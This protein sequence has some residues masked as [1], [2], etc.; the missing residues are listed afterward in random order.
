M[1]TSRIYGEWNKTGRWEEEKN[2]AWW[3]WHRLAAQNEGRADFEP[4]NGLSQRKNEIIELWALYARMAPMVVVEIGVAQGGTFAAWCDL[5]NEN[6]TIIGIDRDVNDCRPRPGDPIHPDI[7]AGKAEST[8]NGGGMHVY[9]RANQQVI[10]INGWT[11]DSYVY[12]RL[13][14]VLSGRKIDF[15][16]HD[17]SHEANMFEADFKRFWPLVSEGGV[18][19]VH[20][21]M[22][23]AN[24][25]CNKSVEWSRIRAAEDYS[26]LYE[27]RGARTDDSLGIGV[28]IK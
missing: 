24:P 27:Y 28:L 22:P 1:S 9:R 8:S 4:N 18:F 19:A 23:S 21:I 13:M 6:A 11:H 5:G 7:F 26:A 15:L 20:D 10:P 17:A 14:N 25:E 3:L 16:F 12:D 2:R